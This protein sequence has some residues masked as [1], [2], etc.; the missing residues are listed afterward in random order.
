MK[1]LS[2]HKNLFV[3]LISD[4]TVPASTTNI[5]TISTSPCGATAII[6]TVPPLA[7]SP[8][9]RVN[10]TSNDQCT[11][12]E[13]NIPQATLSVSQ[14]VALVSPR[15]EN[16]QSDQQIEQSDV[17]TESEVSYYTLQDMP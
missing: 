12:D 3:E 10:E 1:T 4:P 13:S 7:T 11:T 5:D 14:T 17:A 8:I 15:I 2:S 6:A 16:I 9:E